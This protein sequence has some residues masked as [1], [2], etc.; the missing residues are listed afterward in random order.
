[1]AAAH[2][3]TDPAGEPT[4]ILHRCLDPSRVLVSTQGR[5]FVADVGVTEVA[6]WLPAGT[7]EPPSIAPGFVAPELHLGAAASRESD[8]FAAAAIVW[9]LFAGAP[10]L[11]D[12]GGGSRPERATRFRGDVPQQIAAALDQALSPSAKLRTIPSADLVR[13][14]VRAS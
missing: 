1:L 13:M 3:A 14:F 10:P 5:V 6:A 2:G 11:I 8:V 12:P 4:P 7:V 9:S